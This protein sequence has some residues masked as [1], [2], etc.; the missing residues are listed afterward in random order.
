MWSHRRLCHTVP[1]MPPDYLVTIKRLAKD[2]LI[3][4]NAVTPC[5]V[6]KHVLLYSGD[7]KAEKVAFNYAS[8]WITAEVGSFM[9]EDLRD[10]IGDVLKVAER[11][12]CPECNKSQ[13]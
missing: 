5:A 7:S 9:R 13:A 10:A 4:T 3:Q 6:H 2:A 11:N 1:K 8:I 12:G